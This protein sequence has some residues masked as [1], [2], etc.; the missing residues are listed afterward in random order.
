MS[1]NQQ[2]IID[3]IKKNPHI[4]I[5]E[6][7]EIIGIARKNIVNNIKKLQDTGRIVRHGAKKNG[8]WEVVE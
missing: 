1:L 8:W 4:T 7:A 5:T 3:S 6:L 2:K